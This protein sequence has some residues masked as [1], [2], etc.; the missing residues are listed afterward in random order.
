ML[1]KGV[2]SLTELG[3]SLILSHVTACFSL[4]G[5]QCKENNTECIS[6]TARGAF[7]SDKELLPSSAGEVGRTQWHIR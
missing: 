3:F 7:S 2:D 4:L 5:L 1:S 6:V